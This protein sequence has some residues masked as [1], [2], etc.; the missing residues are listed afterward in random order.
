MLSLQSPNLLG[1]SIYRDEINSSLTWYNRSLIIPIVQFPCILTYLCSMYIVHTCWSR[2]YIFSSIAV[3]LWAG[4]FLGRRMSAYVSGWW[5]SSRTSS[6]RWYFLR[7]SL[8]LSIRWS[9]W[10]SFLWVSSRRLLY[11]QSWGILLVNI[12]LLICGVFILGIW[13]DTGRLPIF[14]KPENTTVNTWTPSTHHSCL[15][16][17]HPSCKVHLKF[18]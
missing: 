12:F 1:I 4:W 8:L 10:G 15:P 3:F 5:P 9:F 18:P 16:S 11:F 13:I 17:T 7:P 2:R 14:W 6:I